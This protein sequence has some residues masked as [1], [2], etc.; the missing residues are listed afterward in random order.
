MSAA[1]SSG[2]RQPDDGVDD[3]HDDVRLGDREARLVL[4]GRLDQV[5]RVELEAARVDEH[6]PAP[7][8][9]GVAVQAVAGRVGAIL[10][11]GRRGRRRSG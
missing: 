3:E 2:G 7:V 1:S 6:E 4:D 8:P 9:L 11:D 5:V 10:D